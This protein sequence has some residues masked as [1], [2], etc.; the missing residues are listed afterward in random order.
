MNK[1]SNLKLL[2]DLLD[3]VLRVEWEHYLVLKENLSFQRFKKR[4]LIRSAGVKERYCYLVMEGMA[5]LTLNGKLQKAFPEGYLFMDRSSDAMERPSAQALEALEDSLVVFWEKDWEK[6]MLQ[7]LPVFVELSKRV[8][9]RFHE[10]DNFY[11]RLQS[12]DYNA[13]IPLFRKSYAYLEDRLSR[14]RFAELFGKSTKTISRF[15]LK[16]VE[17]PSQA[18][19][20]KQTGV[21]PRAHP[22]KLRLRRQ[23]QAWVNYYPLLADPE[24]VSYMQ[25]LN[26]PF[27]VVHAFP[28]GREGRVLWVGKLMS[29]LTAVD[30]FMYQFYYGEGA[31]YWGKIKNGFERIMLG[32]AHEEDVPRLLAYFSALDDLL[33]EAKVILD[34]EEELAVSILIRSYLEERQWK[35]ASHTAR[36]P[37]DLDEYLRLRR[38]FSEG[39]LTMSCLKV[40]HRELWSAIAPHQSS[41]EAL[42]EMAIELILISNEMMVENTRAFKDLPHNLVT[43]E[44]RIQNVARKD[45][46]KRLSKAYETGHEEMVRTKEEL[47]VQCP[48]NDQAAVLE[49]IHLVEQQVVAW[50]EWYSKVLSKK[51]TT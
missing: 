4:Q 11:D 44:S 45:I 36:D 41:M 37:S 20:L 13:A 16:N 48:P 28:M 39:R 51:T 19:L 34:K 49:F 47:V 50:P 27:L 5:G 40:V 17:V 15:D 18:P 22:D 2:K 31:M 33:K 30:L 1:L 29:L 9:R 42:M 7:E 3:G 6:S 23:I 38:L 35:A 21:R 14:K 25:G 24:T 8:Y 43:L 10:L 26:L 32:K 12:M 46:L